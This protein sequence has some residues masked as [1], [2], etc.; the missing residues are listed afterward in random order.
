M[1]NV[2]YLAVETITINGRTHT[3]ISD[4][5]TSFEQAKK[6][7]EKMFDSSCRVYPVLS[8]WRNITDKH[9]EHVHVQLADG[10]G[11]YYIVSITQREIHTTEQEQETGERMN[12]AQMDE[13]V[14]SATMFANR[15]KYGYDGEIRGRHYETCVCCGKPVYDDS[16]YRMIHLSGN[17][18]VSDYPHDYP[19]KC[20]SWE[21]GFWRIGNGCYRKFKQVAHNVDVNNYIEHPFDNER[22]SK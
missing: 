18:D 4:A 2:I 19:E 6:Q 11:G 17:G 15:D 9:T 16:K 12:V 13:I 21:Q 8:S 5:F 7:A 14:P 20:Q 1:A 10:N 3:G 22:F